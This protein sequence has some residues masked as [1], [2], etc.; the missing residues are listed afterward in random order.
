MSIRMCV[1]IKA[2]NFAFLYKEFFD[3]DFALFEAG[4]SQH[5]FPKL[6]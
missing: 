5:E 3:L 1:W 4:L 6:D 2:V